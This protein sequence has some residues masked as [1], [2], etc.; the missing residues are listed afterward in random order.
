MKGNLGNAARKETYGVEKAVLLNKEERNGN[1]RLWAV[2]N[3]RRR[4]D[5][6]YGLPTLPVE[7]A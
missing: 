3:L 2:P 7:E 4:S 1:Q 5:I 6:R